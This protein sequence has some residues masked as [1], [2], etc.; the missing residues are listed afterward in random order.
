[1]SYHCI[2][3]DNGVE[4][5]RLEFSPQ[6]WKIS[7]LRIRPNFKPK[8]VKRKHFQVKGRT[9]AGFEIHTSSSG[10]EKLSKTS[11][12]AMQGVQPKGLF[13]KDICLFRQRYL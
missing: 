2:S 9:V 7:S 10:M 6:N 5:I 8:R 12:D 11:H 13:F 3:S 4:V 1:M